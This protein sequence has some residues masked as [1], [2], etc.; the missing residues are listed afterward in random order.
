[1]LGG[2][3]TMDDES[4]GWVRALDG[5]SG[6]IRWSYKADGPVVAG[7]TPSEGGV[8]Y[9]GDMAGHFLALDSSTGQPLF[10]A[11]TGGAVA[12]GVITYTRGG[13]QYVATTSGNVSRLTFGASGAPT[14]ILYTL[15]GN[16]KAGA[17]TGATAVATASATGGERLYATNCSACHGR[18]GEGGVGPVLKG[19]SARLDLDK[20][21]A[22]IKNPSARMPKLHPSPLDDNAVAAIAAYVQ[23]F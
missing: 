16:A 2:T 12:G 22:W 5:R 15:G 19:L 9:T 1:M 13:K 23:R 20:T 17:V 3:W 18:S 14:L 4:F 11:Q 8:V 10:K 6:K 7:I 21:I